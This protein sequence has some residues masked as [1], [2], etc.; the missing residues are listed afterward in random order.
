[1]EYIGGISLA[2]LLSQRG[3][4]TV[5]ASLDI[6]VQIAKALAAAHSAGI[7]HRDVKPASPPQTP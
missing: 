4:L 5:S 6:A 2:E 7:V 1:M 3:P